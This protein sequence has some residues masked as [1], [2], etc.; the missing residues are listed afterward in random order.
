VTVPGEPEQGL[1]H[2]QEAGA[3]GYRNPRH[4]LL[5]A[6]VPPV[7]PVSARDLDHV[8]G[9]GDRLDAVEPE[10]D[11]ATTVKRSSKSWWTCS[12]TTAP[13]G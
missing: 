3:V 7:V 12:P 11:P 6:G 10:G 13:P 9:A 5:L 2:L 8:L 1:D 4:G